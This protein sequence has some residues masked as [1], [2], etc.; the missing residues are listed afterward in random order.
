MFILAFR[1][2]KENVSAAYFNCGG[3]SFYVI[4]NQSINL[5]I[6]QTYSL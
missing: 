2:L 6:N 5:I 1:K 4:E 3:N